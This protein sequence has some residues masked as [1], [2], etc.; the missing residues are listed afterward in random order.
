MRQRV[1]KRLAGAVAAAAIAIPAVAQI[2]SQPATP[3]Q[4]AAAAPAPAQQAASPAAAQQSQP[5]QPTDQSQTQVLN[6]TDTADLS[7]QPAQPVQAVEYPSFARRDPTVAGGISASDVGLN[8][9]LWGDASGPFL[10]TL[11]RRMETPIASRWLHIAL[12]DA[13]LARAPAPRQVNAVDWAAERAWLLL[14]M[15]EADAARLVVASVDSDKFTPKMAQVA[16]QAA[17]ATSDPSGFCADTDQMQKVERT[18]YPLIQAMCQALEGQPESAA[19][20]IDSARRRG[21]VGGIDLALAEK[22]VGAAGESGRAVTVEWEPVQSL[23][24]WR[25][26]LSTATGMSPPDRLMSAASPQVRAWYARSPLIPFA[27]RLDSARIAA[28]L[29][30]FSSQSLVDFYAQVYDA[31]DPNDLGGTDSWQVRLAFAGRDEDTRLGAM[32]RLWDRS[33]DP[34]QKEAAHALVAAAAAGIAPDSKL[35]SDAPDLIASMLAGGLDREASRWSGAVSAMD[36]KDADRCWA[37]LALAAPNPIDLGRL[38]DFIDRDDSADKKRSQLLVAGLAALG[39]LDLA[40]AARLN[41]RYGLNIGRTSNWT[42][43]IDAAADRG[44][45]ATVLVLA[46]T[47]FQSRSFAELPSAHLFHAVAALRRAGQ[48]FT[49]RMIAAEALART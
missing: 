42:A 11:M 33:K 4:P 8:G 40:T 46:G 41:S 37:M 35:E 27:D 22:V 5:A 20:G 38:G 23:T 44:Q 48:G 25:Y 13:L 9:P 12:R 47:G 7:A 2:R 16:A 32:R 15:G 29:G 30:V 43:M 26:G 18:A 3:A 39:R 14:R 36:K 24:A 21:P 49:A 31:T 45:V 6:E 1:S 28:G 19:A 34:L 17:L 10:S